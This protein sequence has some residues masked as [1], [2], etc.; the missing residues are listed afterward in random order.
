MSPRS[1]VDARRGFTLA[2]VLIVLALLALVAGVLIVG[3]ANLMPGN[4]DDPEAALLA[5]LQR[6]RREAVERD[7][8]VEVRIDAEQGVLSWGDAPET[9]VALPPSGQVRVRLLAPVSLGAVLIGGE[10]EEH[11]LERLVIL[12]DGTC[13][14]ARLEVRRNGARRLH[15]IDPMTCAPLPGEDI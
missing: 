10:A 5:A 13:A 1:R 14:P 8:P 7:A 15:D 9:T 4:P 11:P 6:A 12:P 2:E 3:A